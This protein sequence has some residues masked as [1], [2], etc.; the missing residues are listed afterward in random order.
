MWVEAGSPT[1]PRKW[2][3]V[4]KPNRHCR[5]TWVLLF[6]AVIL[7]TNAFGQKRTIAVLDLAGPLTRPQLDTITHRLIEKVNRSREFQSLSRD[8]VREK[9]RAGGYRQEACSEADCAVEAGRILG[10]DLITVGYVGQAG[11]MFFVTLH[12]VDISTGKLHKGV[13]MDLSGPLENV[14]ASGI[15]NVATALLGELEILE[16]KLLAKP[17]TGGVYLS[18]TPPGGSIYIDEAEMPGKVTPTTLMEIPVGH[19]VAKVVKGRMY[20]L[21][22]F[23]LEPDSFRKVD[24]KLDRA[25][26]GAEILAADSATALG[27]SLDDVVAIAGRKS[28][29][30]KL[31]V[32]SEP[33]LASVY[34]DGKMVGKTPVTV[35][36]LLPDMHRVKVIKRGFHR[37]EQDVR[38][39]QG[40]VTKINCVLAPATRPK[41]DKPVTRK[42]R[43]FARRASFGLALGYGAAAAYQHYK[44]RR[45][46]EYYQK[47]S[48]VAAI[49]QHKS[50]TRLADERRD[51]FG[52]IS[53]VFLAYG[54]KLCF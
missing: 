52:I 27:E 3:T 21:A 42:E 29:W 16:K 47:C 4:N 30:G 38:V 31:D 39:W 51:V 19:H 20:G 48:S 7:A 26:L 18:S 46:Y 5:A 49:K 10:L 1:D 40:D 14:M 12:I 2:S 28:P 41:P 11:D 9:L 34:V 32:T 22:E 24:V 17:P 45:H 44:G 33:N 8:T 13:T 23:T 50:D 35:P 15:H 54:V 53:A 43:R 6:F 25:L 36:E 37:C